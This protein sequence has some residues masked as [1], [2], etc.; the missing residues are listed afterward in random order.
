VI[1][2]KNNT[3]YTKTLKKRRNIPKNKR[4]TPLENLNNDYRMLIEM[5]ENPRRLGYISL[6]RKIKP[7]AKEPINLRLLNFKQNIDD[8]IRLL[9]K[10]IL[11]VLGLDKL[12][13]GIKKE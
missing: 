6:I 10:K 9:D 7:T 13:D 5:L 3:I 8:K 11:Y 4:L 12:P 1:N 2:I